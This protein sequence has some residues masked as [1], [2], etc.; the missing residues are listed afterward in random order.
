MFF[1]Y[2]QKCNL[3]SKLD[4]NYPCI[5]RYEN[6]VTTTHVVT[7]LRVP[8]QVKINSVN[9]RKYPFKTNVTHPTDMLRYGCVTKLEESP[10]IKHKI[11]IYSNY[12]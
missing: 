8:K 7:N 1:V 12:L 9:A 10:R 6:K 4:A 3:N 11:N 2:S 5:E